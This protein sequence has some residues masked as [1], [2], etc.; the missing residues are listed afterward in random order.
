MVSERST[1]GKR[2]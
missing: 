2:S 1:P